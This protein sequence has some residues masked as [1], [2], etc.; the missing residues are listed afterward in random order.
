MLTRAGVE[1]DLQVGL[2]RPEGRPL[3]TLEERPFGPALDQR[4][5]YPSRSYARTVAEVQQALRRR[6]GL[7]VVTGDAGMGKTLLCRTLLHEMAEAA[8]VSVV[9]DPRV[10]E[11]DLIAHILVDFGV[12]RAD[13]PIPAQVRR[14]ALTAALQGFLGELIPTSAYAVVI[15][16][17]AQHLSPGVFELLRLLMNFETD[18]AKLLQVVL[19]GQ[20]DLDER[21]RE[22][23]V[24][25]LAQR[26]ARRCE[27]EPLSGFE[28]KRYI[29]R[30]LST[31]QH[32]AGSWPGTFTLSATRAVTAVSKGVP[33]VV[34]QVCD[35]ALEIGQERD[36]RVIDASIVR[37]A[38]RRLHMES[39]AR[40]WPWRMTAA[41]TA[42]FTL[43][44]AGAMAWTSRSQSAPVTV[45]SAR[46]EPTIGTASAPFPADA[47][48]GTL[49]LS[50]GIIVT[51]GSFKSSDRAAAVATQIQGLALPA[52]TRVRDGHWH[53][54]VVGPYLTAEEAAATQRGLAAHGFSD[55][56]TLVEQ[57]RVAPQ[58]ASED[59]RAVLLRSADRTSLVLQLA[60][61]PKKVLTRQ[62]DGSTLEIDLGPL[63]SEQPAARL[64]ASAAV[65]VVSRVDLQSVTS[66]GRDP[67]MR[68]RIA[69][70]DS[71]PSDVRVV[72][73]RVY[74][75]FM[76]AF[77]EGRLKPAPTSVAAVEASV[78]AAGASE[79]AAGAGF[80][81]PADARDGSK[82]TRPTE[83]AA[84][85][86][87]APSAD[88]TTAI[89]PVI[90][91]LTESERFLLSAT[92]APTPEVLAALDR[93][94]SDL[95]AS[96]RAIDAPPAAKESHVL[97]IAAVSQARRA[98]EPDF[99]GDRV[100]QAR[101]AIALWTET[102]RR[103]E[104]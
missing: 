101:Q 65:P 94:L 67:L 22:P 87:A 58:T 43:V 50:S 97:L 17:E 42:A 91:Q 10:T 61:E 57:P 41:A 37:A 12:T 26:V 27:M 68:A 88:Y 36:T 83:P 23:D 60:E 5:L 72:G 103:K 51:A 34:N 2:G 98:V 56:R 59:R 86:N 45:V 3:P 48:V 24:Q 29:E 38:A 46:T 8:F 28:V 19:V 75:D 21:L 55:S 53:Q 80:S 71:T 40:Q 77:T 16:D 66:S 6:D 69:L 102:G 92:A 76:P 11:D 99:S 78:A 54:V 73:R 13:L 18:Q 49:P 39:A 81:R 30:R 1:A 15:I 35:L 20:R 7:I 95:Q 25:A 62:V 93:M 90:A 89:T 84:G 63:V 70:R 4:F 44:G 96:L 14:R 64:N 104:S 31:A 33:R 52:F 32:F 9:L 74:V 47:A 100:M 85:T 82:R 79:A